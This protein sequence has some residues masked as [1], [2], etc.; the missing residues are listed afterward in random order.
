SVVAVAGIAG[1]NRFGRALEAAGY[2]VGELI[3]FRDH[4]RY[5]QRDLDRIAAVAGDRPVLTTEKDAVRLLPRRPLP[6][7]VAV[8][9][10][11]VVVEPAD[12]FRAWLL[13]RL[14]E[15]RA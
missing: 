9:P 7:P 5:R 2:Q 10:L 3:G 8:V 12:V 4:H 13:A 14:R 11:A 15:V 1:P 6:V